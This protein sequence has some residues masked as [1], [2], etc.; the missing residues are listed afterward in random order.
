MHHR[1]LNYDKCLFLEVSPTE[2]VDINT[3]G[4]WELAEL[5]HRGLGVSCCLKAEHVLPA[6]TI[7]VDRQE[8]GSVTTEGPEGPGVDEVDCGR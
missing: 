3:E 6:T 7:M 5:V 2:G 4:D 1:R 8:A